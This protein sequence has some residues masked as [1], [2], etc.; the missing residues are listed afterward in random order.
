MSST[1]LDVAAIRSRFSSL[2]Q[3]FVYFDGPSGTQVPDEV[4]REIDRHLIEANA[5]MGAPFE[6]SRRTT[7]SWPAIAAW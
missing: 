4:I 7:A 5:N 3:P 6:T 1:L 2:D